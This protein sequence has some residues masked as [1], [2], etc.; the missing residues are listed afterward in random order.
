MQDWD[1]WEYDGI[2]FMKN[3]NFHFMQYTGAKDQNYKEIYEGDLITMSERDGVFEVIYLDED[4]SP[5]HPFFPL[6][7]A[8]VLINKVTNDYMDFQW[9]DA[10]YM[11]VIGNIYENP[12]LLESK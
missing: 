11:E 5:D 4:N 7:C 6:M 9:D 3:E 8:F 12:E 2:R 1:S 10:D